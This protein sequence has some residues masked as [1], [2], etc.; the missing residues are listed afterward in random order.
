MF[1]VFDTNVLFYN[2]FGYV[3]VAQDKI[4]L[5][6]T[7]VKLTKDPYLLEKPGRMEVE[8]SI[9]NFKNEFIISFGAWVMGK[10]Q[11]KFAVG[12]MDEYDEQT[13]LENQERL[14]DLI[15][16]V[17]NQFYRIMDKHKE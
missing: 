4:V 9:K 10:D 5:R 2:V 7:A 12:G 17:A 11:I 15:K 6:A 16:K 8:E 3:R 1:D 13:Y 14:D